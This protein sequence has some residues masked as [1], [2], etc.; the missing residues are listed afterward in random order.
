MYY[1]KYFKHILRKYI[2]FIIHKDQSFETSNIQKETIK[3]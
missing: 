1:S 2:F 3:E